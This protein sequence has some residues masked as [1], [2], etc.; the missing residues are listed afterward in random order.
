[1]DAV[2]QIH[3]L[4]MIRHKFPFNTNG[5]RWYTNKFIHWANGFYGAHNE[6]NTQRK[7]TY[8]APWKIPGH[9][10]APIRQKPQEQRQII[11]WPSPP[12]HQCMG[13][14][15]EEKTKAGNKDIRPDHRKTSRLRARVSPFALSDGFFIDCPCSPGFTCWKDP[16]L[17]SWVLL[18][19]P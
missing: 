4:A 3:S 1:M 16:G 14:K 13:P 8:I 17:S 11:L 9:P 12:G 18:T 10:L 5:R 7:Q 2:A 15:V 19:H 6:G